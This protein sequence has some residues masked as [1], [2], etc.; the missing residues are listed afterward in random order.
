MAV[1]LLQRICLVLLVLFAS[2]GTLLGIYLTDYHDKLA[3]KEATDEIIPCSISSAFNCE[4]VQSSKYSVFLG[5]PIAFFGALFY[6][7]VAVLAVAA[8][9]VYRKEYVL[10]IFL[11]SVVSV[12]YSLFLYYVARYI[13]GALCFFCLI[14]YILNASLF[15]LSWLCLGC[16][17]HMLWKEMV[18]FVRSVPS[19]FY[20]SFKEQRLFWLLVLLYVM[21]FVWVLVVY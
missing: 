16:K 19:F 9:I 2:F 6:L 10:I 20:L 1:T 13:I 14:M 15:L 8:L 4:K 3:N 21:G 5:I 11:L 7:T 12:L 17:P 18:L